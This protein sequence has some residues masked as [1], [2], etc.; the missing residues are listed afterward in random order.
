V[1]R[2]RQLSSDPAQQQNAEDDD[3]HSPLPR[4]ALRLRDQRIE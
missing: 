1:E 4:P 2:E 3:D